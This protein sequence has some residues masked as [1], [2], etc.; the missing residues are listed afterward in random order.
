M[1][2]GIP[3]IVLNILKGWAAKVI[4]EKFLKW[5]ILWCARRIVKSTKNTHDDEWFKK[6]EEIIGE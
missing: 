4:S 3:A 1:I 6:L 2:P 5:A